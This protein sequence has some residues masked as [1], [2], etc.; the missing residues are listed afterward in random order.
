VPVD[1]QGLRIER[2]V[3]EQHVVH[4]R[5]RARQRMLVELA[6]HEIVEVKPAARVAG[7]GRLLHC[8]SPRYVPAGSARDQLVNTLF[9]ITAT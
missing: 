6:G 5:D 9:T 7:G 3:G 4:L 2:H 8:P 1:V